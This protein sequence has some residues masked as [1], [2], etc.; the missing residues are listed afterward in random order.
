MKRPK[1]KPRRRSPSPERKPFARYIEF[2]V[3]F[4]QP[5]TKRLEEAYIRKLKAH[6]YYHYYL[7]GSF[8]YKVKGDKFLFFEKWS[9]PVKNAEALKQLFVDG[10]ESFDRVLEMFQNK[11]V[12]PELGR[13]SI[14]FVRY[15]K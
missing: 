4:P 6:T 15:V 13:G 10:G 8:K 12:F 11:D 9:D 5:V 2:T 3:K 14:E 1:S 7:K